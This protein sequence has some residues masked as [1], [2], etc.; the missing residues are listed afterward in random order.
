MV[1]KYSV[2]I[3]TFQEWTGYGNFRAWIFYS[4]FIIF[5][6]TLTIL[7]ITDL[8]HKTFS[9]FS[10]KDKELQNKFNFSDCNNEDDLR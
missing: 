4:M 1:T 8:V 6:L 3:C 5:Y 10:Q 9:L 2:K 7:E